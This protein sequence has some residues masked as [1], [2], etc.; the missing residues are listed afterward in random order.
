MAMTPICRSNTRKSSKARTGKHPLA[1]IF[2]QRKWLSV[3]LELYVHN[4]KQAGALNIS[5][6]LAIV[7]ATKRQG[8]ALSLILINIVSFR[9]AIAGQH[10]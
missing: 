8:W 7:A 10:A 4:V 9:R 2:A 5:P 1:Q 3:S 6:F